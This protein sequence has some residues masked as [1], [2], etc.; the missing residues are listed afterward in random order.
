M[1]V[2]IGIVVTDIDK[3]NAIGSVVIEVFDFVVGK[4]VCDDDV[5]LLL[6]LMTILSF[7]SLPLTAAQ[8]PI[9]LVPDHVPLNH[10]VDD[11][12][13]LLLFLVLDKMQLLLLP[14]VISRITEG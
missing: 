1:G 2:C 13:A 5:I 3:D 6:P 8:E 4:P 7:P 14:A 11:V 9:L 12:G 10:L